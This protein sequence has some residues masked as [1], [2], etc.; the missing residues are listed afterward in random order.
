MLQ[1]LR[2]DSGK[3]VV[4]T[5][6]AGGGSAAALS[7]HRAWGRRLATK[8]AHHLLKLQL[9][10]PMSGFFML[11]REL[12]ERIAPKLSTQGFKI[13]FD[14]VVTAGDSLRIAELP[15]TFRARIYGESKL[16]A[17][18]AFEYLGL[19]FAKATD[20]RVSLRFAL[21]C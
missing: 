19:L 3:L 18:V 4:A 15:Y 13:L 21:F 11:R 7:S 16:D 6:Y 10:D 17:G 9:S 1:L 8:A 5:R 14:I 12:V 2:R 20:D